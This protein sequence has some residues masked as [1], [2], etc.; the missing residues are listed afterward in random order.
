MEVIEKNPFISQKK[1]AEELNLTRSTVA[2][3][4]SAL[5]HKKH[6]LGR[7]YVV[8][9]SKNIYCI[10]AMNVDRKFNLT[11]KMVLQTSNPAISSVSVGGVIRNIAENLGRLGYDVSLFS[12]AGFDEDF[13]II[14][15]ATEPYVNMQHV[16][17]IQGFATGMYNAI[18]D[19]EGEMQLAIADMEINEELNQAWISEYESLLIQAGLII[20]D[21]NLPRETVEYLIDLAYTQDVDLFVIPVS[22]PKMNRLPEDLTGINWLIVNQDES[23]SYFDIEVESDDDFYNLVDRWLAVG[24]EHI[25]ITRG[26]KDS[27]YGN[28][29]GE[30]L[31]LK[32]PTVDKVVDVTGAGDGYSSGV[33]MGHLEGMSPKESIQ[34]GM[35]NSYHIIQG[36][37]NVRHELSKEGLLKEK[38]QLFKKETDE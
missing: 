1:I 32:P 9:R 37:S 18:L 38:M 12:L 24:V 31:S 13:N 25:I 17:Q 5:T 26:V 34:L 19:A 10:G 21:L 28:K 35:T 36:D 20:L 33:I 22:G 30:R 23:E 29:K 2:T 16:S 7:A 6:L 8:N 4:I 11:E 14:K 15:T 3:I 27:A